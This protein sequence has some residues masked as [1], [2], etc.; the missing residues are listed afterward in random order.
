MADSADMAPRSA[1]ISLFF[2]TVVSAMAGCGGGGG[3]AGGAGGG[4][5]GGSGKTCGTISAPDLLTLADVQPA[6]G[7]TVPNQDITHAFTIV[8]APALIQSI[9]LVMPAGKHTAG[10][11]DPTAWS[12]TV[13]PSGADARYVAD[14]V[15]WTTAP[16][17]VY[18][19]VPERF[20][21][22]DGCVFAL[23]DP[24]FSYSVVP[25]G[26]G[27]AGGGGTG[28]GGTGGAP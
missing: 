19:Q 21:T 16:G 9:T 17:D 20:Q 12:F 28:G 5:G 13:M 27:G 11:P 22:P 2:V 14:P 8:N 24:V 1:L 4:A 25:G 18:V 23:P 3:G 15:K 7:S 10:N 6:A 26:A